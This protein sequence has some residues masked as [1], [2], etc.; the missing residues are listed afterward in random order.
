MNRLI[1]HNHFFLQS[2]QDILKI[3]N[4]LI[5]KSKIDIFAFGRAFE[6]GSIIILS[7]NADIITTRLKAPSGHSSLYY[8]EGL[9]LWNEFLPKEEFSELKNIGVS[10][11]ASIIKERK[12]H[13]DMFG[14]ASSDARAGLN[15]FLNEQSALNKF[16]HYFSEEAEHIINSAYNYR[17][18]QE[19]SYKPDQEPHVSL[20]FINELLEQDISTIYLN[21]SQSIRLTER[22]KTCLEKFIKGKNTVAIGKELGISEKTV[23]T[24]LMRIRNKLNCSNNEELIS[25]LW[26]NQI[27]SSS[28]FS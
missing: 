27:I 10:I 9:H 5:C 6:D 12:G 15:Y 28:Y 1:Q 8:K 14:F 18:K 20:Y 21:D 3:S 16:A 13:Y 23:R 22:E 4:P 17:Y 19:I 7:N 24:Y 2:T 25:I 26:N 11:G